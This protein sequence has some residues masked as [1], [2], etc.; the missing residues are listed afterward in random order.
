[1][2]MAIFFKLKIY[3]I[4]N[5][6]K[7]DYNSFMCIGSTSIF[8]SF[9]LALLACISYFNYNKIEK[10]FKNVIYFKSRKS[11]KNEKTFS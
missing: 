5:E 4:A 1:M 10:F 7:K 2:N 8:S 11:D 3:K 9:L 6:V